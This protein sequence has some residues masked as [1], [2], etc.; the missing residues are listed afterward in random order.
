V[1]G[2]IRYTAPRAKPA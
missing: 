2:Q 1:P